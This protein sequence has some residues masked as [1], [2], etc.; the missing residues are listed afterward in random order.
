M[1]T[2]DC[3]S[4]DTEPHC[5][6]CW[7]HIDPG[8]GV[9]E[10]CNHIIFISNPYGDVEFD[11]ENLCKDLVVDDETWELDAREEKLNK[12]GSNYIQFKV[13]ISHHHHPSSFIF[14]EE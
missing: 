10:N 13:E 9:F 3:L 4:S 12:L 5:P 1:I 6:F 8:D 2:Y 14:K 11:R 7:E